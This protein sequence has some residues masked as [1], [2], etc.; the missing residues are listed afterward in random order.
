MNKAPMTELHKVEFTFSGVFTFDCFGSDREAGPEPMMAY[1]C[2]RPSGTVTM[3]SI[4]IR[5]K[6]KQWITTKLP[7]WQ[8]VM[9]ENVIEDGLRKEGVAYRERIR[10]EA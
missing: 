2:L 1:Y 5:N 8:E 6:D 7:R 10:A 4:W 9:I 3:A